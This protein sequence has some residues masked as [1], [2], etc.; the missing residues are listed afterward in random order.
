MPTE[1]LIGIPVVGSVL[2]L[3]LNGWN[4][5]MRRRAA[6]EQ[7]KL[8]AAQA[9]RD[10]ALQGMVRLI[11]PADVPQAVAG[12]GQ[13]SL[14]VVGT[15]GARNLPALLN[16]FAQAG[17]ASLVGN[18]LLIELDSSERDRCIRNI[19][20]LFL[21]R[22]TVATTPN[23]SAGLGGDRPQDVLAASEYWSQDIKS[24]TEKWLAG[25]Q[26]DSESA[27]LAAL[28]SPGGHASLGVQP[29]RMYLNRYSRNPAYGFTTYDEKTAVRERF[30]TVRSLY[31]DVARG[32]ILFDNRRFP[33]RS[34]LGLCLLLASSTAS[35]SIADQTLSPVNSLAYVFD[36]D[37]GTRF[38]TLSVFAETL[39]VYRLPAEGRHLPEVFY[40]QAARLEEKL[41]TGI[42]TVIEHPEL[43]AAPID[44]STLGKT[45]L[46]LESAPVKPQP[47]FQRSARRVTEAVEEWRK[48]DPDIGIQ[49]ASIGFPLN[50]E[51]QEVP[52]FVVLLQG[53]DADAEAV[54]AVALGA[55]VASKFL[56]VPIVPTGVKLLPKPRV[57]RQ[58]TRKEN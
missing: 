9:K 28:I 36:R 37:Q 11:S 15:Y 12:R 13:I 25:M 19:N 10:E 7:A 39:P 22:L 32:I 30:P 18:I 14:L 33:R 24:A 48:H 51:T 21:S 20:P 4:R 46:V 45:R 42:R 23:Y 38:A 44:R 34:D 3:G 26:H 17:C 31:E 54:D 27:L 57:A 50:A 43:Q 6:R 35:A 2:F 58:R 52:M 40:T 53:L 49:F 55:P 47:D 16:A 56:A 1:L 29:M 41:I 5:E 8:N